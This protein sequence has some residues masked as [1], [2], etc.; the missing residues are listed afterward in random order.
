M[1]GKAMIVSVGTGKEGKDIAHGICF[2][3]QHHN[4]DFIVFLNTAKSGETTMPYIIEDCKL[5]QRKWREINLIDADDIEKIAIEC[6]EAIRGLRDEGYSLNGIVADYTSGT[7]AMSAG[8]TIAAIREKIAILTYT[9][10]K[11]G[12]GGRVISGT[13]R[14]LSLIPNQI[15]AEDLFKEAV[16]SFNGYHFDVALKII[17]EAKV[18]LPEP[19]FLNKVDLLEHLCEA[20]AAWDRFEI[21]G[22]F[23][24]LKALREEP[25]LCDWRIDKQISLNKQALYQEK[26]KLF[27]PER[28][29]D[30]VENAKRRGDE[31]HKYDDAVARLYRVCEYVGQFEIFKRELYKARDGRPDTS[32]LDIS[33]LPETLREKYL[34]HK[35]SYDGKVKLHLSRNYDLLYDL[36]HP[37][38]AFFKRE[39]KRFKKLM[40]LR[41]L[42]IL[43]H[44]FNPISEDT[45]KDMLRLVE[46]LIITN[47]LDDIRVGEKVRFPKIKLE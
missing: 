42:S 46:E 16:D 38:G 27:C 29:L 26:E 11:R 31:E 14:V 2:S 44:G 4:P 20:Y 33:R 18:L 12:E 36:D 10:G 35:D 21:G 32:D 23:E 7:K 17:G 19:D 34:R 30:L 22:A 8:L 15:F 1:A 3:L 43:A 25:L 9:T 5:N 13:E 40:G 24:V 45:Y 37:L 28:T 6:Q 47:G 41:D 39:E